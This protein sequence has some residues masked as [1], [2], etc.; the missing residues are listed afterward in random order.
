MGTILEGLRFGNRE[1]EALRERLRDVRVGVE[2]EYHIDNLPEEYATGMSSREIALKIDSMRSV[3][4]MKQVSADLEQF[5]PIISTISQQVNFQRN[6]SKALGQFH[7]FYTEEPFEI[8]SE[9][10]DDY[11]GY[12]RGHVEL[13]SNELADTMRGV[14]MGV[15]VIMNL[16]E[17]VGMMAHAAFEAHHHGD[18]AGISQFINTHTEIETLLETGVS[19]FNYVNDSIVV[20]DISGLSA[21]PTDEALKSLVQLRSA[22][23][24]AEFKW[25]GSAIK[26]TLAELSDGFKWA[27]AKEAYESIKR[28]LIEQHQKAWDVETRASVITKIRETNPEHNFVGY[29]RSLLGGANKWGVPPSGIENIIL[30]HS[31]VDGV[32]VIS[33]PLPFNQQLD[34]MQGMFEHIGEI[35]R[36]SKTTGLHVNISIKGRNFDAE[37][38]DPLKLAI[39]LDTQYMYSVFP[40]RAYVESI[41]KHV[42]GPAL[43]KMAMDSSVEVD[44]DDTKKLFTTDIPYL[45]RAL[46]N[47][48][49]YGGKYQGLNFDNMVVP[50]KNQ[51]RIEFRYPGGEGY[52]KRFDEIKDIMLRYVYVMFAA[53]DKDFGRQEYMLKFAQQLDRLAKARFNM[54]WTQLVSMVRHNKDKIKS[55]GAKDFDGS[56]LVS[57]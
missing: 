51:Q 47:L 22:L 13:D 17:S 27:G 26:T 40:V 12:V 31:V 54:S 36:T 50:K 19:F 16:K 28:S 32:E 5:E 24:N 2:Y 42:S 52:E 3:E 41:Y 7:R 43:L 37:N 20:P 38:F 39:L 44:A 18:V 1:R 46:M 23:E 15:A 21:R 4:V 45:Q 9:M 10:I 53:Y 14:A 25:V 49:R 29:V 48:I 34:F 8:W 35:G 56:E 30:D 33:K 57:V 55:L 6:N 11:V